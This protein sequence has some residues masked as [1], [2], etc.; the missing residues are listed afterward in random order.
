M[1]AVL[2]CHSQIFEPCTLCV[3]IYGIYVFPQQIQLEYFTILLDLTNGVF[4]SKAKK[5]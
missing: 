2:I 5:E 4:K 3:F 1:N